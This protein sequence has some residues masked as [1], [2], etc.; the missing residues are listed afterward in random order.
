VILEDFPAQ[1][2]IVLRSPF[3][4]ERRI[5]GVLFTNFS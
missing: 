1:L 3:Q 4:A 2:I 5:S